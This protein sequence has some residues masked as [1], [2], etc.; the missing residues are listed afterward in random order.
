MTERI[1]FAVLIVF[2]YAGLTGLAYADTV[3][4]WNAIALDVIVAADPPRPGPSNVLDIAVVHAAI[5]DAV[6]AID[7]R[8]KPYHTEIPGASG[9]PAAAAAK[10]AH[11]VLVNRFPNQAASIDMI[12]EAYLIDNGL[13][14]DDPGIAVGQEA[15]AG[16]IALRADDGSFPTDSPPLTGGTEPGVWRP[17]PSFL[18]GP[19]PGLSP[20]AA[21]W[22]AT[23]TPFTLT[24]PSQF[25]PLLPPDLTSGRY[26]KD[27]NEVKELGALSNSTRTDEQTELAHFWATAYVFVWNETVREIAEAHVDSIGDSARLFALV[28]MSMADAGITAWDAKVHYLFWRPLTAIQ[29]GENDGNERTIGDP[30]WQPLYNNPNYPDYTSGASALTGAV[31][32][33]LALFFAGRGITFSVTTTSPSAVQKTRTFNRFWDAAEEVVDARVYEGIHFRTADKLGV[34]QGRRV[35]GWAFKHFLRP[36]DEEDTDDELDCE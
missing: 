5:Y 6:A 7:G 27:Y 21:P 34:Q 29:E 26:T 22:L 10:A 12:Y 20:F 3:V 14:S 17:T 11:D 23:V 28:T 2:A 30:G 33:A 13:A 8:F 36:V 25:R 24:S 15:A 31:T 4:D 32:Q 16:I 9:S 1:R 35:A 19:P 18:P